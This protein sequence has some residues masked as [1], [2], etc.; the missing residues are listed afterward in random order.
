MEQ[1]AIN[2][3]ENQTHQQNHYTICRWNAQLKRVYKMD[4]QQQQQEK[5]TQT[6]L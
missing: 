4:G 1:V 2:R 3:I 6:Y 5:S